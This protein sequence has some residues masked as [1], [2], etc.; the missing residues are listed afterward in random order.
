MVW[1]QTTYASRHIIPLHAGALVAVFA[2]RARRDHLR[3]RRSPSLP[4]HRP[5][6]RTRAR[7]PHPARRRQP[8]PA[9]HRAVHRTRPRTRRRR[10]ELRQRR[11]PLAR[12]AMWRAR[13]AIPATTDTRQMNHTGGV[14]TA[15]YAPFLN[16][17]RLQRQRPYDTMELLHKRIASAVSIPHSGRT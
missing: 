11:A 6:R 4:L 2:R 16:D 5:A 9:R 8:R 7:A 17:I 13:R 12:G 10:R 14:N 1:Y 3:A 15:Q